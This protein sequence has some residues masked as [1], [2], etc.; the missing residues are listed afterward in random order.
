MRRT[1]LFFVSALV[2]AGAALATSQ[3]GGNPVIDVPPAPTVV[4][5]PTTTTAPTTEPS[6]TGVTDSAVPPPAVE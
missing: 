1:L 3:L 2:V 4:P 5:V 6:P